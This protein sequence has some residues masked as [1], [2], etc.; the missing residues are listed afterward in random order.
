MEYSDAGDSCV[1]SSKDYLDG[2]VID[3]TG[4]YILQFGKTFH[5]ANLFRVEK[6]VQVLPAD[7]LSYALLISKWYNNII[8]KLMIILI[9]INLFTVMYSVS[10]NV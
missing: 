9:I 10:L 4:Y 6:A 7:G 1:C 3:Q 2:T 5:D 8:D